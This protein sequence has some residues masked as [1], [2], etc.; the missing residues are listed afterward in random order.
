MKVV[1]AACM[2]HYADLDAALTFEEM[3][4]YSDVL[5]EWHGP[6]C[7]ATQDEHQAAL[8]MVEAVE[9]FQAAS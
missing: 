2:L 1:C 7:T 6:Y 5:A 9:A 4:V 8:Q 3:I